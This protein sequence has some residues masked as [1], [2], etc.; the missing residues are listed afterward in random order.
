MSTNMQKHTNGKLK[1]GMYWASSC[2]GC[3]ISLLEIGPRILELIQL[4][5]VV[6]WPCVADF[7]YQD[8]AGYPDGYMDACFYNGG[9]RSSEQEEIARLL[10]QKS[11]TLIG[12]GACAVGGG[13]PALANLKSRAELYDVVY[14]QNPSIDNRGGVEPEPLH[15]VSQ[16][17]LEL[18]EFYPA[19]LRLKDVVPV[20]Y[21]IPGCPPQADR[22]WE[23]IQALVTGAVPPRNTAVR[24][25]CFD[26]TVCDEC[27]REKK[28]VKIK[29]F[30]RHHQFRP[31]PNWCLLEQGILCMGPATRSG[32]GALCLKADVACE[33]CYGAP[34][35]A[36]DQ[37]T[38]MVGALGALLDAPTEERAR[39]MVAEIADPTGTFYR[40]SLSS[41]FMKL[42]K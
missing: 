19:V 6:L 8:V 3:D 37:G 7:K 10:R 16:G 26:K 24:V 28:L 38:C 11:K 21:E 31:E 5:D 32:C 41:S 12:Y 36:E 17:E 13:I 33:G 2:G 20:D 39:E 30:R 23:S 29:A 27:S 14:H 15:E 42:G 40:F 1:I 22:V 4:A 34:A 35:N 9:V 18:P 25:G